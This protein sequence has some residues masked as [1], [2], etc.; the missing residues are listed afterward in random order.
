MKS[1]N[2]TFQFLFSIYG[3]LIF[4]A[5]MIL[6]L[7]LF[8]YAFCLKPIKGGNLVVKLAHVWAG[9]LF[10]MTGIRTS[11]IY[12]APH[13]RTKEYIFISNHISY[14][15]I[16]MM[17]KVI[18]GQNFR[19]LGKAEMAKIPIFG[20][21]YKRGAVIVDR[22]N[23]EARK[24]SVKKLIKFINK[25]I[26]VFICPEGTF[27][28]THQPLKF[29]YDGAFRIAIDTQKP[30]KP[31][32]FLD[33]YERLSYESLFSLTPGKS[34]AVYLSEISTTGLT[35]DD[36]QALKS[37]VFEKMEEALVRYHASWIIKKG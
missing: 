11:V 6:L 5:G 3:F 28:K 2:K 22:E 14:L 18:F 23:P 9:I 31:I 15:D 24:Q 27:N 7:P 10:F 26:S 30:I 1:V 12:E 21:I 17:V 35:Q 25:K 16:P 32:L 4:L 29:F 19:V 36:V 37:K 8:V 33:T 34:R 13:D 20:A